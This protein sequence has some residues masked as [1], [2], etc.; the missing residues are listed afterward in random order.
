MRTTAS[1][2]DISHLAHGFYG[3]KAITPY[4]AKFLKI[5]K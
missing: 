1:T 5:A 4:G 3:I 2:I